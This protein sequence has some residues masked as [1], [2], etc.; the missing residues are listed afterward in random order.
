LVIDASKPACHSGTPRAASKATKLFAESPANSRPRD[1]RRS[2]LHI[3]EALFNACR[4]VGLQGSNTNFLICAVSERLRYP[5][6]TTDADFAGYA[7]VIP[8]L[9]YQEQERV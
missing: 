1:P 6:L 8:V 5:I 9:L 7:G 3:S 2:R 4:A